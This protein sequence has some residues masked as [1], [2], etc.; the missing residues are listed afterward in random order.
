MTQALFTDELAP[1]RK[2]AKSTL[3]DFEVAEYVYTPPPPSSKDDALIAILD[4]PLDPN[5]TAFLGFRRKEQELAMVFATLTI[6]ESRHMHTRLANP[7]ANDTLA[8]KFARLT[9]ERRAR[10]INFIADARRRQALAA[11]CR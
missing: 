8:T 4:E 2:K 3:G 1:R 9:H 6:V 10:L 11:A 5:E 7:R